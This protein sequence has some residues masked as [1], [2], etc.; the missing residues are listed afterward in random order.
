MNQEIEIEFKQL[1]DERTYHQLLDFYY[2]ER[3]PVQVQTNH[4]FDTAHYLLRS[5]GAA[6]RVRRKSN[7]YILTLKEPHANGLL[8]TH[9]ELSPNTFET[10]KAE[11]TLPSGNVAKQVKNLLEAYL[12]N[13][14]Y[15]GY[16]KTERSEVPIKDAGLLVLDRSLYFDAIDYEL[17]FEC[18][19]EATGQHAFR[20]LLQKWN[21]TENTPPNKIQRF[22]DAR[23]ARESGK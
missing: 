8:E 10:F 16:L 9:Q 18:T 23:Q 20:Q 6:L 22:F 11:G 2:S 14:Q 1:L 15:L 4:Y 7:R 5:K 3:S 13:F 12:P 21:L 17:E 19:D